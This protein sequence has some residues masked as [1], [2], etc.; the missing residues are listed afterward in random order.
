MAKPARAP[1]HTQHKMDLMA[2]GKAA[3]RGFDN[4][5]YLAAETKELKR[6][7]KFF[8]GRLY[9]EIGGKFY[10]D[11][12]AARVLPGYDPDSKVRM[13]AAMQKG[14]KTKVELVHC[15][16][17]LMIFEGK[18][19]GDSDKLYSDQLIDDVKMLSEK[20]LPTE[21]IF[22]SRICDRTKSAAD[23]MKAR[24]E[25]EFGKRHG[26]RI[27][28]GHDL[29]NYPFDV[30]GILSDKGFGRQDYLHADEG[31]TV[32]TAPGPGSGKMAFCMEQMYNDRMRLS[33]ICSGYAKVETF[34]V[35]NMPLTHPVNIAYEAAT[36]DIGDYNVID[37][38]HKKA[39]GISAVNYNR[40]VDNFE[41]LQKIILGMAKRDDPLR[42]IKSPTD[43]GIGMTKAGIVSDK[44]VREA[45][46]AEIVRRTFQYAE[47]FAQGK[48]SE[49]I[50]ERMKRI[51][52]KAGLSE[53]K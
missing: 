27:L 39:Y 37:R 14:G 44:V 43:M 21:A 18:R 17:S 48:V 46:E 15:I 35:W 4:K 40:D 47:L 5:K 16:S 28:I 6:R 49:D 45:A 26:I 29:P 36:A 12:H 50:V 52:A 41:I 24:L 7:V 1:E 53:R 13:L 10:H 2:L 31:I 11:N 38:F 25:K 34:P 23:H 32:V 8:G 51:L 19:R 3:K 33:P 30:E 22:I 20:G 42:S 9:L